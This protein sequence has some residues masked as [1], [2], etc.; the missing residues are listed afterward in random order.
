MRIEENCVMEILEVYQPKTHSGIGHAMSLN[1]IPDPSI[2]K[3]NYI[4][5]EL[6]KI[7][8]ELRKKKNQNLMGSL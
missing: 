4:R 3:N 5:Y 8:S 7:L 1:G 6:R 2:T